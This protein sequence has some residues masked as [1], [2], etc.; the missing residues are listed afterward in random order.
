MADIGIGSSQLAVVV[1]SN[2][3]G[4]LLNGNDHPL[5]LSPTDHKSPLHGAPPGK[6]WRFNAYS[7]VSPG[8]SSLQGSPRSLEYH[9]P[10]KMGRHG[11]IKVEQELSLSPLGSDPTELFCS[12]CAKLCEQDEQDIFFPAKLLAKWVNLCWIKRR[13]L[14]K[15][16]L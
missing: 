15:I 3:E 16:G 5:A 8:P 2:F 14:W 7:G 4:R 1:P 6:L 12:P 10:W 13:K 11:Y 9:A